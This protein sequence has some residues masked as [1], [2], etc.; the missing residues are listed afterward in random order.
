MTDKVQNLS[1][2]TLSYTDI[3]EAVDA[4]HRLRSE[5]IIRLGH[6]AGAGLKKAY[7]GVGKAFADLT[8]RTAMTAERREEFALP[9]L[10][11]RV[12]YD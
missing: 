1:G 10:K 4:A 2:P 12:N 3:R 11:G 8:L 9:I 6:A 5:E 7:K